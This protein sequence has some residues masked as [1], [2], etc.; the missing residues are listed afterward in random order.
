[1]FAMLR[2]SQP[3][4]A[5]EQFGRRTFLLTRYDDCLAALKDDEAFSSRSN[6]EAGQVLGRGRVRPANRCASD[7]P[8]AR[9]VAE[10]GGGVR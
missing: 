5:A 2:A 4:L 9:Q 10:P 6:A 3:V 8:R 1:M 7:A